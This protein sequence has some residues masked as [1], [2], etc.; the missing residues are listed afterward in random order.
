[1]STTTENIEIKLYVKGPTETRDI[2]ISLTSHIGMLYLKVMN[3]FGRDEII[4]LYHNG[5]YLQPSV[6]KRIKHLSLQ[7]LSEIEMKFEFVESSSV[8]KNLLKNVEI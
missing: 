3:T 4:Y 7:N 6:R 8:M 2:K 1:M 5:V